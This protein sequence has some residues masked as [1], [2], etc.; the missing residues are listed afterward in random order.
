MHGHRTRL[1]E[2]I[3]RRLAFRFLGKAMYVDMGH[4]DGIDAW[5]VGL[6]EQGLVAPVIRVEKFER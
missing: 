4:V 6:R 2:I 5:E 3:R 1:A